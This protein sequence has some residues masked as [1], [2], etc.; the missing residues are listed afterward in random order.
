MLNKVK[1]KAR[2]VVENGVADIQLDALELRNERNWMAFEL[3]HKTRTTSTA[4][5]ISITP[6]GLIV[7]SPACVE[8]YAKDAAF[9]EVYFDAHS[10]RIGI[11]PVKKRDKHSYKLMR[12][13]QSKRASFSGRGFVK[14]HRISKESNG[15]FE[16]RTFDVRFE[17]GMI[18]AD[19][20]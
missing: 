11:K 5:T 7:L 20:K 1:H 4:E 6:A 19:T 8:N 9:V 15:K 2:D 17:N 12:P 18:V 10:K 3:F 16:P 14:A 13:R